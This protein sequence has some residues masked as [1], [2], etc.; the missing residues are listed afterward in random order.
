MNI[1]NPGCGV[2]GHCIAV[3]PWFII[4]NAPEEAQ[5]IRQ[6]RLVN[7]NKPLWVL[8]KIHSALASIDKPTKEVRIAC[9]GLAFKPNIDDLRESPALQITKALAAIYPGQVLAVEPHITQCPPQLQNSGVRL[10]SVQEALAQAD[11]VVMLVAH[12]AFKGITPANVIQMIDTYGH[13]A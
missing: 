7:E 2:G 3:D 12:D 4:Q 13:L 5:L 1:L 10:A 11:I 6:A 8:E 9:F